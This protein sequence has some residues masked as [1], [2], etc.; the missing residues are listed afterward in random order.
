MNQETDIYMQ[1]VKGDMRLG[2][3]IT[4]TVFDGKTI[5]LTVE[6]VKTP[7]NK[8]AVAHIGKDIQIVGF[9]EDEQT[10]ISDPAQSEF[11][12]EDPAEPEEG[13]AQSA[14]CETCEK[15]F[16][17]SEMT[18]DDEDV[19]VCSECKESDA[20]EADIPCSVCKELFTTENVLWDDK[21]KANFCSD[22]LVEAEAD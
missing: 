8:D 16:P 10:D 17:I 22:C 4:K 6:V 20:D 21:K 3:E 1:E 11:P 5:K 14:L 2:G 9:R 12:P 19:Y 18:K 7:A 15:A 13:D